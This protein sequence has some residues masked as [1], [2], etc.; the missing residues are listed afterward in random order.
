MSP[1]ARTALAAT[2]V[3]A[4]AGAASG[5]L[6]DEY[7]GAAGALEWLLRTLV[8]VSAAVALGAGFVLV[9]RLRRRVTPRPL[10]WALS[11]VAAAAFAFFV[12]QP[13][14]YAVYLSHLP[15][16]RASMKPSSARPSSP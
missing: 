11:V 8:V 16:R 6:I 1:A 15:T 14:V 3:F 7:G 9:L 5:L 4:V 10:G 13:V 12:V 2:L